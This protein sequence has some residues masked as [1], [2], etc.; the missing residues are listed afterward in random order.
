MSPILVVDQENAQE[1][2]SSSFEGPEKLLELWF[3]A[4]FNPGSLNGNTKFGLK[5]VSRDLWDDMLSRAQCKVLSVVSS[6]EVDAYLLSESSMFVFPHKIILKTCGTTTLLASLPRLLEIASSVGFTHPL[7]TFYSRKNFL[8]PERQLAP[9]TSWNDEV[10]YLQLFFPKGSSYVVGPTNKNHWYLFSDVA[11][12]SDL[13]ESSL[14]P[15]DETL[16]VL[17]TN[18]SPERSLQFYAPSLDV[19]HQSKGEDYMKPQ[20]S[21]QPLL[22]TGHILGTYMAELSGVKELCSTKDGKSVLD[23]FQ[24]E[25]I[26]F[27]SNMIYKDRYATIHVTPQDH[28]SYASFETNV[29]KTQFGRS[30]METIEKAVKT[31]GAGNFSLTLFQAKGSAHEKQLYEKLKHFES[32]KR[33]EFIVYDFPGYELVF[34]S[35]SSV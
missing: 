18:M 10:R 4:P 8:Y 3:S 13:F 15:E 27:S 9:H 25:P 28:C 2:N 35:F 30:T 19:V 5:N 7:R 29:S 23:A 11:D 14:D 33:E 21:D 31:F 12:E 34:A 1:F 24:F 17:M 22:S 16:E 20:N 6:N 26:G 32:Y